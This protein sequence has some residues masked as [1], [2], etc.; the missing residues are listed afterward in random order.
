M[1][2]VCSTLS[3]AGL[4]LKANNQKRPDWLKRRAAVLARS[5]SPPQ[6]KTES[7][8]G[9]LTSVQVAKQPE[10]MFFH[11]TNY[12]VKTPAA[13][14]R[15]ICARCS[16][17]E[18]A[19]WRTDEDSRL[20]CHACDKYKQ[21]AGLHDNSSVKRMRTL[22]QHHAASAPY[23]ERSYRPGRGSYSGPAAALSYSSIQLA[24]LT[25]GAG[26]GRLT[27]HRHTFSASAVELISPPSSPEDNMTI[28]ES[29]K[30][31]LVRPISPKMHQHAQD[32]MD[33]RRSQTPTSP[34]SEGEGVERLQSHTK[35]TLALRCKITGRMNTSQISPMDP[36]SKKGLMSIHHLLS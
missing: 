6:D 18:S 26:T 1:L 22:R 25:I 5:P 29:F 27:A 16:S 33:F 8:A 19:V 36:S 2:A 21:P 30:N 35:P 28:Q 31:H 17:V 32:L 15:T 24:P 12:V 3:P 20:I 23:P 13:P 10:Q 14:L 7:D 34:L 4:Y 9:R 11:W